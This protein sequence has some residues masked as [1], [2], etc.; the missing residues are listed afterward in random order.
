LITKNFAMTA[1]ARRVF[2]VVF[3]GLVL[4][5]CD[6]GNDDHWLGSPD[7]PARVPE[8]V[9]IDALPLPPTAPSNAAGACTVEINPNRTGCLDASRAGIDG[10][11][12]FTPDGTQVYVSVRFAGAPEAPDPASAYRGGQ[13][14][15][16]KTDGTTFPNGDAWRCVTC[17]VPEANKVGMINPDDNTYPEAFHDGMRVKMGRNILDCSPYKITDPA[18][19]PEA[20][21]IYGIKSPFPTYRLMRE[22]RLHPDNVH[23]GWNQLIL[24]PDVTGATQFGVFGRLEFNPLSAVDGTPGYELKN[25]SFM[26]SPELG[27]SG[28]FFSVGAPGE[29]IFEPPTGVIGEFR[30]FTPDGK[31]TIGMGTQDSFNYD[32][33]VTSLETGESTRL[34]RDPAYTDPANVSPDG[35]SIVILDGRVTADTGYPGANPAGSDGRL[36]FASAGI[37]VPPLLDMAIAEAIAGTYTT[38]SRGSFLQPVLIDLQEPLRVDDPNI[39]DG[40]QLNLGGDPAAGSGSISDPLW[41][42]GADPA[43]SPDSTAVVYYQ[44]RGCNPAPATCPP[45]TEPGGR[46]SRLLIARL[47]DRKP[48]QPLPPP[49]PVDDLIPWGIPYTLGDPLPPVRPIVPAGT[50]TLMGE[51]GSAEVVITDGP[52]RFNEG[53]LEVVSVSVRYANYSADGFNFVDGTESGIRG[54]SAGGSTFTWHSD[55]TFSG[56]H[57]GTRKT[58]EPGGFVVTLSGLGAAGKFSGTLTTTLDGT[59]FNSPTF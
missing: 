8:T 19:T 4:T 2:Y 36:Y 53:E 26:L 35:K 52:S 42:A 58:S 6:D 24:T 30:G 47:T 16:V 7:S 9:V 43:W 50:Y 29:L 59:T 28:R 15:L 37:G 57:E 39:H 12:S 54:E 41:L 10:A 27:K 45:S 34:S 38:P 55:L 46:N 56:L 31:S 21:H 5:A 51:S 44:R 25:V 49:D 14:M 40:Q 33:F 20:T 13:L 18:C 17:G 23:L 3:L 22:L 48:S 11:R 32:I 1:A